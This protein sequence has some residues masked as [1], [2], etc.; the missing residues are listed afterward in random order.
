MIRRHRV[1]ARSGAEAGAILRHSQG[2]PK[3]WL[4]R[5]DGLRALP[6]D[7]RWPEPPSPFSGR[8]KRGGGRDSTG[9][10]CR[11]IEAE[12]AGLVRIS[13]GSVAERGAGPCTRQSG[14]GLPGFAARSVAELLNYQLAFVSAS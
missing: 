11:Q 7:R 3:H 1:D 6:T 9:A 5:L 10:G 12:A 8:T 13:A 2:S 4:F 14:S